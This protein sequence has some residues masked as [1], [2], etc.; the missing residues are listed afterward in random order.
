[1]CSQILLSVKD[2][3]PSGKRVSIFDFLFRPGGG[4]SGIPDREQPPE[5]YLEL[6]S[7]WAEGTEVAAMILQG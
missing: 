1:M 5:E 7:L 4:G 6:G 2:S 3:S